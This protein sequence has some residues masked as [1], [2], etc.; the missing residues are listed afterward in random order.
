M[1]LGGLAGVGLG[2]ALAI[3][4]G[5]VGQLMQGRREHRK[6]LSENQRDEYRELLDA[7]T[8]TMIQTVRWHDLNPR[9]T[10]LEQQWQ[11]AWND[12]LKVIHTRIY[13]AKALDE[14]NI[15]DKWSSAFVEFNKTRDT[16]ALADKFESLRRTIV[17][18]A[19]KG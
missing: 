17:A 8:M 15:Y 6:W 11:A 2:G 5:V 7:L 1:D 13:I 4:G 10:E 3:A 9:S 14:A 12:A 19:T 16:D 18:L